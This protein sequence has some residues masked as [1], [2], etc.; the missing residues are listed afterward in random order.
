VAHPLGLGVLVSLSKLASSVKD[1]KLQKFRKVT[2][3]KKAATLHLAVRKLF[4][5]FGARGFKVVQVIFDGEKSLGT[6]CDDIE[7]LGAEAIQLGTGSHAGSVERRAR[8]I[9]ERSRGVINTLPFNMFKLL[10]EPLLLYC[11]MRINEMP[12]ISPI[13]G[14]GRSPVENFTGI[15]TT[16]K[17]NYALCF[18]DIVQVHEDP[19]ITNTP[20]SRTRG[21]IALMPM[22]NDE[23]S[24]R[25]IMLD[26][27]R[28]V[29]RARWTWTGPVHASVIDKINRKALADF[30]KKGLFNLALKVQSPAPQESDDSSEATSDDSSDES[31][32]VAT[33]APPTD[34]TNRT[35]SPGSSD[36]SSSES[37][38]EDEKSSSAPEA[39]TNDRITT[40]VSDSSTSSSSDSD[41]SDH[42][43]TRPPEDAFRRNTRINRAAAGRGGKQRKRSPLREPSAQTRYATRSRGPIHDNAMF[44]VD[45]VDDWVNHS[46]CQT[47][48]RR[49]SVEAHYTAMRDIARERERVDNYVYLNIPVPK[50]IRRDR[51]TAFASIYKELL[52][53]HTQSV[54]SGQ[55]PSKLTKEDWESIIPSSMFLKDK[56]DPEGMF[57][58]LK[59]RLVAGGH[60]QDRSIYD[61]SEI[62]SPAVSASAAF[63][64]A[65]IAAREERHVATMDITGAYLNSFMTGKKVLMRL[66]PLLSVIL[67]SIEPKYNK[68]LTKSQTLIVKLDKALYGT[69]EAGKL[70][71]TNISETL[72]ADGYVMNP[73]DVCVFN[74]TVDG[75]QITIA[76]YVDDFLVTSVSEALIDDLEKLLRDKYKNLTANRDAVL[77]YLGMTL[78]F[79]VPRKVK[80]TMNG[81]VEEMLKDYGVTGSAKTPATGKLFD[82]DLNLPKLDKAEATI[83]HSRVAKLLYLVK[84]VRPDALTAVAFLTTRVQCCTTEDRDKLNRL[85]R[86]LNGTKTFGVILEADKELCILAYIDASYGVHADGKSHT[87]LLI[88]LGRGGVYM[89]SG[90]QKI[91]TKS[92]TEAELVALTDSLSQVI[93]TRD[94]IIGQGYVMPPAKVKQDNMSTMALVK[95]GHST[96]DRTRHIHVRYFFAKDRADSGEIVIEHCP[97]DLMLADSLTKPLQ[98]ELFFKM[99]KALLNWEE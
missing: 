52:Q 7:I 47:N 16:V 34:M 4:A 3:N 37:E 87:G 56:F 31:V 75:I 23:G 27:W 46:D 50:A 42:E 17:R 86:Y 1:K 45:E 73:K 91:V 74:K 84:R 98:G 96:S 40:G 36:D 65:S 58:K 19:T 76:L 62:S 6:I 39:L 38:S 79:S 18:G 15:Q 26:S 41:D 30:G 5:M 21:A 55:D 82:I 14:N 97:T 11:N 93:W 83:F 66:D 43:D 2:G 25:F 20:K 22:C 35:V 49:T 81:Y 88:S 60:M 24:W 68:F 70:W 63:I 10:V 95:K 44:A 90:K 85:L 80:V 32:D 12:S 64:I 61:E 28:E 53:M 8:V 77:S 29:V 33:H 67:C 59:A 13:G 9:G 57:E 92:S 89:K 78:D 48:E 51:D 94:F 69:L 99:R 54:L 72:I 71:Y